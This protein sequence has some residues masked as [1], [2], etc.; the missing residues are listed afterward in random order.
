MCHYLYG[1]MLEIVLNHESIWWFAN[2]IDFER[3]YAIIQYSKSS[4]N[5][6]GNEYINIGLEDIIHE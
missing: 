1:M 2:Q 5:R 3:L 6:W 4:Y